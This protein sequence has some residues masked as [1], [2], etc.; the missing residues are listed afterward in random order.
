MDPAANV[1]A[2]A[3]RFI[4]R[5]MLGQKDAALADT[6][7]RD[8]SMIFQSPRTA[9]NPIR[10]VG[11]QIEDV[12]RR[13]AGVPAKEVRSRAVEALRRT[14]I[15][16]PERRYH[17]YPFELSGGLCQRVMIAMALACTP[18]LLIADEPTT[19]LDVTTQA[20]VMD[21]IRDQVRESGTS[22][23]LITHDLALAGEYCDRVLVMHAG[24]VVESAPIAELLR[25][26]AHPYTAR[27]IGATPGAE[28][29]IEDLAAIPGTLPDLRGDLPPCRFLYRCDRSDLRCGTQPLPRTQIRPGHSLRCWNPL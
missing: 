28:T 13:H 22:V 9:L 6:R 7:G 1:R 8:I 3:L 19:G 5:D 12:L 23:I 15:P 27:L 25:H 26:P 10:K 18:R 20:V 16:D 17:A 29:A 24:H 4:G 21:L 11:F 2:G 14:R